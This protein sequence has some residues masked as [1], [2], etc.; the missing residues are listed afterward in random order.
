MKPHVRDRLTRP[1]RQNSMRRITA[2]LVVLCAAL[3]LSV[4][5]HGSA[6]QNQPSSSPLVIEGGTLIDGNG[7]SP[8]RDAVI[9]IE[10]NR[11]TSVSRKGSGSYPP[12]AQVL[13]ADGKFIVPGLW[14]SET[15]YYWYMG[16]AM[17]MHGV[18]STVDIG[19]GAEL[20]L[21]HAKAVQHGKIGGPRTFAG[22]SMSGGSDGR[23]TGFETPLSPDRVP[24]TAAE[25]REIAR[26]FVDGGAA[27]VVFNDGTLPLEYV[28][29]GFEET[30][31]A[32]KPAFI[33]PTGPSVEPRDAILAGADAIT[34]AAGIDKV[35]ARD[36]SAYRGNQTVI[37]GY[38]YMDDGK[39]AE[40]IDLL[41]RH[42]VTLVPSLFRRAIGFHKGAARFEEEDRRLFSDPVLRSYYPEDRIENMLL[43]YDR[44][45]LD[46][47]AAE[48]RAKAYQNAL[49][50]FR[51]FVQAGGRI[52]TGSD[53]PNNCTPG[54]CVH[55]ELEIFE[56]VGLT[57]QQM[58][59]S[60]TKW[61]AELLRVANDLGTL[62]AGKLADI[63]IV[64]ADPLS[65]IRNLRKIEWVIFGG[66]VQDRAFHSWYRTPFLSNVSRSGNPVV[67]ALPWV[68]ALKQ[69]TFQEG[70]GR[71]ADPPTLPP[72]GIE[73][74]SPYIATEGDP[75]LALVIKGFNFFRRSQ[76]YFNGVPVPSERVSGTE[77][78]AI[79]D[80]AFLRKAGRFDITVRNPGPLRDNEGWGDGISNRAHLL[81]DFKY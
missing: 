72:P 24:K 8:V 9:V 18:T 45:A 58:I 27:F 56:E 65:D 13:R 40:M 15:N 30:K 70:E 69:T 46:A 53:A 41:V 19:N 42:N 37:D 33:R 35:I 34:H 64:S 38:F 14:D 7:G 51:Q 48:R 79:I 50:F 59:Q 62:E 28:R 1:A 31:K 76:V 71:A 78:R 43:N 73:T 6:A 81:V 25:A 54:L 4:Y 77:L 68:V 21:R 75:T 22:L 44:P 12:N 10:G 63:V 80:E 16:E 74:I 39:A 57:P 3:F 17:L 29:A 2:S 61:P 32:G 36:A 26:R 55:H 60:V 23:D 11:I 66:K 47:A 5:P 49:R 52:L 20:A 67:E